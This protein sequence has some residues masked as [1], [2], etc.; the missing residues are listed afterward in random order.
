MLLAGLLVAAGFPAQAAAS[1]YL[2][3]LSAQARQRALAV[4][5]RSVA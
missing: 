1:D 2:E 4:V 3:E 5:E